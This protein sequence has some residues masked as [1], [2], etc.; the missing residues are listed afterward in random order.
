MNWYLGFAAVLCILSA[1]AAAAIA[2]SLGKHRGSRVLTLFNIVFAGVF[3]SVF[4][5][6]LPIYSEILSDTTDR[7]LKTIAFSLHNT[8]QAFTIDTDREIIMESIRCPKEWLSAFYSAYLSVAFVVAPILTFGF[9]LSFFKN[10]SAFAKYLLHFFSDVYVFSELNEKSL[11]LGAD[12]KQN[13]KRALIV[14]TDVF[15]NNEEVSYELV[16]R[17]R[18][19]KAILFK[20]D[21]LA[22]NFGAHCKRSQIIFYTIGGDE[23]ENIDQSL[24]LIERYRGRENTRLF[25]FSSRIDGE[26]LLTRADKGKLKVRRVNEVRSLVN[27]ILY[28]RG[29]KLFENAKPMPNGDRK[30]AAVIVGLG[31]YGTE[32]LKALTWYCQMDGYHVE[33]DVFDADETAEDRFSAI[34]PELMSEQYNGVT[35][36]EEAEYTIRIHSGVGVGTKTFADAIAECT[37][38]TYAFISLGSD[39]RNIEAAVELRMLFERMRIKP[40]I[41]SVIYSSDERAALEGITNYRGQ[42]YDIGFIGDRKTSYSEA[43]IMNSELEAFALR[44]HLKWGKEEEFWQYEYNY[45]S[46]VASAIHLRARIACGVPGADKKEEDLTDAERQTIERLEH[47]RWNAYMRSEGYVFS[48][49]SDKRSRNDLA[50]MHH[51]LVD[52][53]SLTDEEKRKDSRVGTN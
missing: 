24:R 14:Y 11:S 3:L 12:I 26:L 45:N 36:P 49:S 25:V 23:T 53:S 28:E 37:D 43:V 10:A 13:H 7:T 40:V 8:F 27:R 17:A 46:S 19:I 51:D 5:C 20:K 34:A 48:G 18:E 39:E 2:I 41:Q 50:K 1:A 30:I 9:V 32:M 44:R 21:V 6:L 15:E 16:E 38:T 22:V 47:R 4:V 33:I 52:Y 29:E 35:I 31:R 42:A